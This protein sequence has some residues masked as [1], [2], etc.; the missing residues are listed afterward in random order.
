MKIR[1]VVQ[2]NR[3]K[4]FEVKTS[5]GVL[6]YPFAKLEKPPRRHDKIER[7]YVDKELAKEAFTYVLESGVED[8]VHIEQVLEYNQDP[9][10]L[11]ELLLYKLTLEA[12]RRVEKSDLSKREIIRRLGTSAAQFY[13]LLDQ[14]NYRKSVDRLLELL[15]VLDCD[16]DLVVREKSA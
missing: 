9:T 3:K 15:H 10:Y 7:V 14:T 5:T 13:R 1:S 4:A 6:P 12:Q 16:V 11:R 2:N 8:S